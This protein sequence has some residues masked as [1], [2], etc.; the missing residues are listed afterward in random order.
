MGRLGRRRTSPAQQQGHSGFGQRTAR[1]KESAADHF[2]DAIDP[3][4]GGRRADHRERKTSSPGRN[5]GAPKVGHW[6]SSARSPHN[7]AHFSIIKSTLGRRRPRSSNPSEDALARKRRRHTHPN[8]KK[9]RNFGRVYVAG[10]SLLG[11]GPAASSP[12]GQ[13]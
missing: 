12:S 1:E 9:L 7:E 4:K 3:A 13:E 11:L 2:R 8:A 6:S 5:K 10:S